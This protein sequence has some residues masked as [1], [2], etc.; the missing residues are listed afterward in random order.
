MLRN[1]VE[2]QSGPA[3]PNEE[4]APLTAPAKAV[5]RTYPGAPYEPDNVDQPRRPRSERAPSGITTPRTE[6]DDVEMS[7]PASPVP[8][9]ETT[10]A[11]PSVWDPYMN[12]F[13]LL[14]VCLSNFGNALN[15]GAAGAIIP[16]M[17]K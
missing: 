10:E 14:A 6:N 17:E 8:S 1:L 7:R 11:L 15:D 4:S 5:P 13:R 16:Y 12:R 2:V 3:S 9:G